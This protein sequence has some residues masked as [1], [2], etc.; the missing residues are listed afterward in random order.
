MSA[1][2]PEIGGRAPLPIEVEAGKTYWWCALRA[3]Q[4]A[5][6][7]RRLAQGHGTSRRWNGQAQAAEQGLVL[8][9]QALGHASRCATAA[10]SRLPADIES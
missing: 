5:A 10:T 2:M 1:M 4:V 7:L 9:L 3:L 8:R 6:V